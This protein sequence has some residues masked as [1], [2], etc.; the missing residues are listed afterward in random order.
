MHARDLC[1]RGWGDVGV[2][3]LC[4]ADDDVQLSGT[5]HTQTY[6]HRGHQKYSNHQGVEEGGQC[7]EGAE[8]GAIWRKAEEGAPGVNAPW[9]DTFQR[10]GSG[11][12]GGRREGSARR[13]SPASACAPEERY[14][15]AC[16]H[17]PPQKLKLLTFTCYTS[18]WA[19]F[20]FP[21][22]LPVAYQQMDTFSD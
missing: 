1:R 2:V 11:D 18:T 8:R 7:G 5:S 15:A 20:A 17:T 12:A 10:S 13:D 4:A 9:R 22:S 6:K 14:S 21:P 19:L 3:V 16:K